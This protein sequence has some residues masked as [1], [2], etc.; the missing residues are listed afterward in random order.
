MGRDKVG[1]MKTITITVGKMTTI[2]GIGEEEFVYAF[3]PGLSFRAADSISRVTVSMDPNLASKALP[4]IRTA[5]QSANG[6]DCVI[7]GT[8]VEVNIRVGVMIVPVGR[9]EI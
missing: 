9:V 8:L 5:V 6:V 1:V 4:L 7:E 3:D 2:L